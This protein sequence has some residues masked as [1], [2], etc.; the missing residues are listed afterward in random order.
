MEQNTNPQVFI[1]Y[2]W[3]SDEHKEKVTHFVQELRSSGIQ[4]IYDKDLKL[5]TRLPHFMEDSI[6]N[7][8]FVLFICSPEYKKRA[9]DRKAG[10]GYESQIITGELYRT[11]NEEKFIPILFDGTW[12]SSLPG[13][14]EGKLGIDL[15]SQALYSTNFPG[16][17]SNLKKNDSNIDSNKGMPKYSDTKISSNEEHLDAPSFTG[18]TS[19]FLREHLNPSTSLGLLLITVIAGVIVNNLPPLIPAPPSNSNGDTSK[20]FSINSSAIKTESLKV[21]ISNIAAIMQ[22]I[23]IDSLMPDISTPN[24]AILDDDILAILPNGTAPKGTTPI[25]ISLPDGTEEKLSFIQELTI[26]NS[27][28]WI[29]NK[30]GPAFAEATLPIK[31]SR[32]LNSVDKDEKNSEI[33]ACVYNISDIAIVQ[34][35][36]DTTNQSCQAFFVTLRQDISDIEIGLP[37]AYSSLVSNKTLGEFPFSEIPESQLYTYGF[38]GQGVS[39]TFYGEEHYLGAMGNYQH[40][41]F[42]VLDYGALNSLSD[43]ILFVSRIQHDIAPAIDSSEIILPKSLSSQRYKFYP[44]TYGIS[45]LGNYLTFDLLTD[46]YWFDSYSLRIES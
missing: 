39:R 3:D 13:W 38:A 31:D 27:K 21:G 10:V 41:Y 43:F 40:F 36:F 7:S 8:D 5:G 11:S 37:K 25:S 24:D 33:L 15:S 28:K 4:V 22:N 1:S 9:D 32:L 35:Y 17:L 42:A 19:R 12:E 2:S 30:L 45:T 23:D 14:A 6:L 20:N 34:V 29:D 44:N 26:G 16:L 18:K 46:Y